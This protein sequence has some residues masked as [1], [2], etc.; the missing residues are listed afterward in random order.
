[1]AIVATLAFIA[2]AQAE[3]QNPAPKNPFA[4]YDQ[5]QFA[6]LRMDAPYAGYD[7]Q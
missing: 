6:A 4:G 1:M 2:S 7:P 3:P 5:Y